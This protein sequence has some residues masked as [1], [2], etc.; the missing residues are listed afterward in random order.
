MGQV[1]KCGILCSQ[2]PYLQWLLGLYTVFVGYL[3]LLGHTYWVAKLA[4]EVCPQLAAHVWVCCAR[5][6]HQLGTIFFV[7]MGFQVPGCT[8]WLAGVSGL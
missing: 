8:G 4:S 2:I 5:V 6:E 1:P 7:D 3:D